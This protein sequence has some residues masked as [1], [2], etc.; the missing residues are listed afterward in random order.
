[1]TSNWLRPDRVGVLPAGSTRVAAVI[2]DPVRHSF[3]PILHNAGFQ[4][5]QLDW[6][7]VAFPVAQGQASRALEAMTALS[8]GGLSVTM[9]HKQ[10]VA[11]ALGSSLSRAAARLGAVNCVRWDGNA[12]VGENTDGDGF[13]DALRQELGVDPAGAS[14]AVF[15]AGGAGRAV[16]AALADAGVE[17]LVVINRDQARAQQAVTLGGQYAS[18][19]DQSV[20]GEMDIIIN[21][22][23]VGMGIH[24]IDPRRQPEL[25]FD[26]AALGPGHIVADLVYQPV[27]TGLL[28]AAERAGAR[29]LNGVGMLLYQ[30]VRAFELWT[31]HAAPVLAMR[32]AVEG[33]LLA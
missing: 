3:S 2:G 16:V 32:E 18:V 14:V 28:E 5:A 6:V 30:A 33:Y 24:P 11:E 27:R 7:Y 1:M 29:T 8:F 21:A 9:P 20:V 26:P 17:R 19:G 25:P 31:G 23:S 10:A 22:T 15:G 12:L 13:I 4:A